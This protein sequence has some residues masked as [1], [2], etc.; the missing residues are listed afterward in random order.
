MADDLTEL[1]IWGLGMFLLG[2]AVG[3]AIVCIALRPFAVMREFREFE[4]Q[5]KRAP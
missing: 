5:R 1:L 2:I 4:A 3:V